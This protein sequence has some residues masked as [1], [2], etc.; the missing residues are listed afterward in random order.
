MAATDESVWARGPG[1]LESMWR[2]RFRVAAI[3][4]LFAVLGYVSATLTP[5]RYEAVGRLLLV[6]PRQSGV[7]ENPAG[8]DPV[9]YVLRQ[10]DILESRAVLTRAV[11]IIGTDLDAGGL[12]RHVEVTPV[13]DLLRVDILGSAPTAE[14][15]ATFANGVAEAFQLVTS[16]RVTADAIR[17]SQEL[18][19]A[20]RELQSQIDT[21]EAQTGV[22]GTA[23]GRLD[24]LV[25]QLLDL[26]S[27]AQQVRVDAA[28]FGSGVEVYESAE[29]PDAPAAPRPARITAIA[30]I[31][32]LG[33]GAA[34]AYWSAGRSTRIRDRSDAEAVLGAP[35]LGDVPFF[36]SAAADPLHLGADPGAGES[37]AFLLNSI[38]FAL[39]DGGRKVL[40]TSAGASEGKT[41][42]ALHL[43]AAAAADGQR[44][45]VIDADLRARGLSRLLGA[46][47]LPGLSDT[48]VND[49]VD[50]AAA[51]Y[52]CWVAGTIRLPVL[53]AG[54]HATE[55][56]T[57]VRTERAAEVLGELSPSYDLMIVD[58]APVLAVSDTA[59]LIDAVDGVVLV[60]KHRS[61][62]E[63]LRRVRERLAFT[64]TP[65][66]GYIYMS[67]NRQM[68]G[69]GYGYGYG[70]RSVDTTAA[71]SPLDRVRR[72]LPTGR[73]RNGH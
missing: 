73:D 14:E 52:H 43:A 40:L 8:N 36:R 5:T 49:A 46:E 13:P 22:D 7:F 30:L 31:F 10:A 53:A 41:L 21:L 2:H 4:M 71:S 66:L 17:V 65:L 25:G 70:P 68:S 59:A 18:D 11:E 35:L 42:T 39:G 29:V 33:V 12:G 69:Y 55:T 48:L 54:R 28:I 45:L 60:V 50:P 23:N 34:F 37:F 58:S 3:G 56:T 24:I 47:L 20:R 15:A 19:E 72:L 27:R 44:A 51:V 64:R 63:Q 6:D 9:S 16:E 62:H 26:E 61:S 67:P 57:T 32:G 1:L 38:E